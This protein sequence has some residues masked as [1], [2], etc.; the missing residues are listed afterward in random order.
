MAM[1]FGVVGC[2]AIS[3]LY[4]LPALGRSSDATLVTTVDVDAGHGHL[5]VADLGPDLAPTG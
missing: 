4:Q 5:A 2:G 3:T 1:R